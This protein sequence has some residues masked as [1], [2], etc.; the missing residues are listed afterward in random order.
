MTPEQLKNQLALE[1]ERLNRVMAEDLAAA[2][3]DRSRLAAVLEH[4]LLAGGKRIRPL[5]T[6]LA[7][8]LTAE[9]KKGETLD[10]LA[11][12]FEYLHAASLL[13]DDVI[14]HAALR[15]GRESV[16]ARWDNGHAILAGDFLHARAMLL[17]GTAGGTE[18]LR[19]IGSATQAMVESEFIQ[20]AAAATADQREETYFKVLAGKTAALIA[21]ACECGV[22]AGGGSPEQRRALHTYGANL[23]LAFQIIDDLLDYQ[24]DPA[25]TGK[26]VGNDLREGKM[27]L[28]IIIALQTAAPE[29]REWL[30]RLLAAGPE[31]RTAQL[32]AVIALLE[33]SGAFA[34]ARQ[35]AEELIAK[36]CAGLNPDSVP[37][38]G[39]GAE[40]TALLQALGHYVL[41]RKK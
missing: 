36:G 27:T 28:P 39:P 26:A 32:P 21:A 7:A 24:G 19:L 8:R 9:G 6:L 40:A 10:R 33:E 20:L 31:E 41:N 2:V 3:G 5:L 17:A 29:G 14:D 4:A 38:G 23:G 15:R 35:R 12:S 22:L 11:I 18:A 37:P 1:A 25:V 34:A 13:H 16:N 30:A